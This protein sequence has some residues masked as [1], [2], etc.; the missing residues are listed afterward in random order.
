MFF[1]GH[2]WEGP[3][4]VNC[5]VINNSVS[6][7]N[8]NPNMICMPYFIEELNYQ[9]EDAR[10]LYFTNFVGNTRSHE[11]REQLVKSLMSYHQNGG[12][13]P[14]CLTTSSV[15]YAHLPEEQKRERRVP[16]LDAMYRSFTSLCP[17]GAGL[18][19]ERFFEAMC[20]GRIP[21]LIS[22]NCTLPLE[23]SIDWDSCILRISEDGVK[24]IG[25]ILESFM[26]KYDNPALMRMFVRNRLTWEKFFQPSQAQ[27]LYHMELSKILSTL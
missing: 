23:D 12:R 13:V 4:D 27:F 8:S 3:Y 11:I 21:I 5:T 14:I 2:D 10:I 20:M 24:N 16:F 19:S 9:P 25:N 6:K 26:S 15:H 22:D 17:R 18:S 7:L 1:S